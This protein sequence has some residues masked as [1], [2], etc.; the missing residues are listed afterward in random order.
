LCALP[1]RGCD[2]H[3]TAVPANAPVNSQILRRAGHQ[4]V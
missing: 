1:V 2:G 3:E 4:G